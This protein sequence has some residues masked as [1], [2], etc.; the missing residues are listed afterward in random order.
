LDQVLINALSSTGL[1]L[2][3][4]YWR[5]FKKCGFEILILLV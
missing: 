3:C 1:L 4:L 5:R 2:I